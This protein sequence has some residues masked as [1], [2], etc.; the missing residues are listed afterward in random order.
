MVFTCSSI[1]ADSLGLSHTHKH[2]LARSPF[3]SLIQEENPFKCLKDA[4]L[5]EFTTHVGCSWIYSLLSLAWSL[6]FS[7]SSLHWPPP[8][9]SHPTSIHLLLSCPLLSSLQLSPSLFVFSVPLSS[10]R[11]QTSPS[12]LSAS[13]SKV[14]IGPLSRPS[15]W[16]P[17]PWY[18]RIL[19][20]RRRRSLPTPQ[21]CISKPN[22]VQK[23]V[24]VSIF[25]FICCCCLLSFKMC[26]CT[27]V[28]LRSDPPSTVC[29]ENV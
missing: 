10:L 6:P 17:S 28:T 5:I 2:T 19:S 15:N 24:T 20:F 23:Y 8:A 25:M 13:S 14:Q 3:P 9:S 11:R 1:A 12:L 26:F 29:A 22:T 21:K 27:R 4:C 18:S 16:P 7:P